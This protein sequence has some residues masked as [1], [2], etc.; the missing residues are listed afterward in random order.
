L[1]IIET[2]DNIYKTLS[3]VANMSRL[4]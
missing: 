2:E 4:L 3:K 1:L